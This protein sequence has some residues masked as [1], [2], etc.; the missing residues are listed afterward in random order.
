MNLSRTPLDGE[1]N[2][3]FRAGDP[4]G[5][6]WIDVNVG[7]LLNGLDLGGD[8]AGQ[9]LDPGYLGIEF[10]V[11]PA[12]RFQLGKILSSLLFQP[13]QLNIS[14]TT[15]DTHVAHIYEKFE[16]RNAPSAINKAHR[17][18]LFPPDE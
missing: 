5:G 7:K 3:P 15:V 6:E 18:G 4:T 13:D 8:L 2:R 10:V 1:H 16:V 17:P 14:Y 11:G 9:Y 12:L